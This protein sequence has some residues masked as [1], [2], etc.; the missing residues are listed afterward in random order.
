MT[1]V[2]RP[3]PPWA[4]GPGLYKEA[5]QGTGELA[6]LLSL[7]T[8]VQFPEPRWYLTT[9]CKSC[10]SITGKKLMFPLGLFGHYMHMMRTH[11]CWAN[12]Y[13]ENKNK[14]PSKRQAIRLS[15][16]WGLGAFFHGLCFCPHLYSGMESDLSCELK[17]S[18][19][20]QVSLWFC[21]GLIT[22]TETELDHTPHLSSSSL[23]P[24]LSL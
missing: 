5:G 21:C 14:S 24:E 19:P 17:K 9:T 15:K 12:A 10:K 23:K 7:K 13:T 11:P 20:F 3:S 2:G 16:P 4:G 6:Q 22:A 18:F 8:Q 1:D